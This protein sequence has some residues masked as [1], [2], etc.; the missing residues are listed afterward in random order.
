[1]QKW[2]DIVAMFNFYISHTHEGL[3]GGA[4]IKI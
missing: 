1:M 4:K 2:E 3:S